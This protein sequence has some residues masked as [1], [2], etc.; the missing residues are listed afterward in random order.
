[1]SKHPYKVSTAHCSLSNTLQ[2]HLELL[3]VQ[4][5][6]QHFRG[7]HIGRSGIVSCEVYRILEDLKYMLFQN[8]IFYLKEMS[9]FFLAK[10]MKKRTNAS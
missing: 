8:E 10:M 7:L 5:T 1:M 4:Q 9:F 3:K 6:I 2:H